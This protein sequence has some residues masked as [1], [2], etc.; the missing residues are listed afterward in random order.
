ML[1]QE[2]PSVDEFGS[3][4]SSE[5]GGAATAPCAEEEEEEEE[6]IEEIEEVEVLVGGARTVHEQQ[7]SRVGQE[8]AGDRDALLLQAN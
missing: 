5:E 7:L 8:H 4:P 1:R 6:E 3:E 2:P